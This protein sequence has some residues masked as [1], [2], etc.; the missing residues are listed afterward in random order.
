M[1]R[2]RS[3]WVHPAARS[4]SM[5]SWEVH[6]IPCRQGLS[7]C[8]P[9]SAFNPLQSLIKAHVIRVILC[10]HGGSCKHSFGP[11]VG[12]SHCVEF[13]KTLKSVLLRALFAHLGSSHSWA[14][15]ASMYLCLASQPTHRPTWPQYNNRGISKQTRHQYCP[16]RHQY[17][18]GIPI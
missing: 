18:V 6:L 9:H 1:A 4:T 15:V 13:P 3:L 17:N 12:R 8:S 5:Q 16:S 2:V 7:R 10:L 11:P 14:L